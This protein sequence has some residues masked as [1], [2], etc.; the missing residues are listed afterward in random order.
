MNKNQSYKIITDLAVDNIE[1]VSV[2]TEN[3]KFKPFIVKTIYRPPEKPV[4]LYDRFP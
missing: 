2:Q 3:G 4:S 1:S